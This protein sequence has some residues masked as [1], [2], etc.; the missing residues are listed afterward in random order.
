M[1]SPR[2]TYSRYKI[3][4]DREKCGMH[5]K[6][7]AKDFDAGTSFART[8]AYCS[9]GVA[10]PQ[11]ENLPPLEYTSGKPGKFRFI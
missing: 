8:S 7:I 6:C 4:K 1:L 9:L 3:G 5:Q 11:I 2:V 10:K